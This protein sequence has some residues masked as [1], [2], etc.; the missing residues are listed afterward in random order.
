[1]SGSNVVPLRFERNAVEVIY[2]V[3]GNSAFLGAL[4]LLDS[5]V[6]S[7]VRPAIEMAETLEAHRDD[8]Q[9]LRKLVMYAEQRKVNGPVGV[10]L[11][12]LRIFVGGL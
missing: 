8:I 10:P 2:G 7:L 1:M 4:G 12:I 6:D 3:S 11:H 9:A 5:T